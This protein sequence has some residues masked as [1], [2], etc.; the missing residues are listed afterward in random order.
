MTLI[1]DVFASEAPV[2]ETAAAS[3]D[4][5]LGSM[6]INAPLFGFQLLN[7]AIVFSIIWFLI[8]KPLSKKLTE[9]QKMIDDSID[10][11]KKIE[12]VLKQSEKKYQERIDIAKAEANAILER[13]KIEADFIA[14]EMKNKT[15]NDMEVLVAQAK[16]RIMAEKD[17][18]V[19][20]LKKETAGL[21]VEALEKILGEKMDEAKDKKLITAALKDIK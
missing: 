2:E 3:S 9:R 21:V 11:S 12:E 14:E 19:T 20:G 10:N 6:G 1:E 16:S 17:D 13:A 15:K 5:I 7:F 18:M 8:L 4:G